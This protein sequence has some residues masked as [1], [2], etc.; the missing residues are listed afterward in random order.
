MPMYFG[1]TFVDSDH[2]VIDQQIHG[3]YTDTD[4]METAINLKE[5]EGTLDGEA[6]IAAT[7]RFELCTDDVPEL[8]SSP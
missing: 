1:I 5:D 7:V 6:M 2:I 3:P 8:V 4:V